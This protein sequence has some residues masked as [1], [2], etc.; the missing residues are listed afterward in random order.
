MEPGQRAGSG[1]AAAGFRSPRPSAGA[2]TERG[3]AGALGALGGNNETGLLAVDP[4]LRGGW[5]HRRES[6]VLRRREL[7]FCE[8]EGSDV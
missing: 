5:R 6:H 3:L 7:L 8:A 4:S 1:K 2:C